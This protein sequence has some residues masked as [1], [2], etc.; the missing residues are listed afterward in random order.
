MSRGNL[1]DLVAYGV[2]NNT[3]VIVILF[4]HSRQVVAPPLFKNLAVIV[5]LFTPGPH[6]K[7]LVHHIDTQ[8]VARPEGHR[9]HGVVGGA[10][11]V[12]ARLFQQA[13]TSKLRF[14]KGSRP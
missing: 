12:E 9:S 4:H 11:R 10:H 6:V 1:R 13:H 5:I 7:G 8:D 2:Q 3:G 14:F